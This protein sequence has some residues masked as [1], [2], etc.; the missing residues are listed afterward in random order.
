MIAPAKELVEWASIAAD[1]VTAAGI[2]AAVF[3]L[4]KHFQFR[5]AERKEQELNIYFHYRAVH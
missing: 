4:I 5:Y 2:V 3:A 1:I